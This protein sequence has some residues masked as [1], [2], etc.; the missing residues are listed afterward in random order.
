MI[1]SEH[2][3]EFANNKLDKSKLIH[4]AMGFSHACILDSH[5][6]EDGRTDSIDFV[7]AIGARSVFQDDSDDVSEKFK[8]FRKEEQDWLFGGLTYELREQLHNTKSSLPKRFN[9]EPLRFFVPKHL[10]L[11]SNSGWTYTGPNYQNA[12]ALLSEIESTEIKTEQKISAELFVGM[13]KHEYE[14]KIIKIKE[15]IQRGDIYEMNFCQEFL[16]ENTEVQAASLYDDLCALSRPPFSGLLK[17]EDQYLI[18]ASPERYLKKRGARLISQPIK[19]TR[20][21][22]KTDEEDRELKMDL[23]QSQKDRSEN[24][25]IVDLVRNDFSRLAIPGSVQVEELFGLYS[26]PTV[27]Q[28]VSTVA[29]E[30]KE[31]VEFEDILKASYPMGS[32]TG[33]PK[34]RAM[35]IIEAFENCQRSWYSG[36]M[37][38]I[39]PTGDF[40][41]SVV[42][43]SMIYD[44]TQK[45]LNFEVGGAITIGSDVQAEYEECFIKA[46]ALFGALGY[47]ERPS[48]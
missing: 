47:K 36:S 25:M 45:I 1:R 33:A 16:F 14:E 35:E 26:F 24:V 39:D 18:S 3:I 38:Y 22:G 46:E 30:L 29:C 43:R 10:F 19:G 32:M 48:F 28:M 20:A 17:W 34:I 9:I 13:S 6:N 27:H 15:H 8:S 41:F 44:A 31:G 7:A 21:R 40:D 2:R 11:L 23:A 12:E 4:W 5:S 37:G 42:I